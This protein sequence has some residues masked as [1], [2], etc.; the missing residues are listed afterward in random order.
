LKKS[1]DYP[2]ANASLDHLVSAQPGLIPQISGKLTG[3]RVNGA[4]IFVDHYSDHVYVSLMW[5]LTLDETNLAK[6]A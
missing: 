4:T 3:M 6:H 1:D 2:G 5:D